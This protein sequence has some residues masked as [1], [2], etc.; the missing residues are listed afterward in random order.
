MNIPSLPEQRQINKH[1]ASFETE[2]FQLCDEFSAQSLLV[3]KLRQTILQEAIEGKLTADWRKENPVFSGGTEHDGAALL[4]KIKTK[5]RKL[6]EQGKLRKEK[7][8]APVTPEEVPFAL[9]EGWLWTRLG[10]VVN[11]ASNIVDPLKYQNFLQ[12][13]PDNIEKMTGKLKGE[14][15]TVKE[16]EV[17]SANHLFYSGMLLYSKIRPRLRK[18]VKVDFDGLCSA[19]MYPLKPMVNIDYIKYYMLSDYFDEEVYKFDN[20]VKMPKINKNQLNSIVIPLPP[21]A[22]QRAIVEYIDKLFAI[23]DNLETQVKERKAQVEGLMQA[24]LREAFESTESQKQDNS[25]KQITKFQQMQI[26]GAVIDEINRVHQ[27]QGEMIIAKYLYIL[28]YVYKIKTGFTFQKWHFGPYDISLKKIINN[29]TYFT[30]SGKYVFQT[31]GIKNQD[32]LFKY[33]N[34]QVEE[35]RN[36]FPKIL[37]IFRAYKTSSDRDRKIELLACVLKII[38]GLEI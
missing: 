32:K 2:L 38:E 15:M 25:G 20:R 27:H 1:F 35:I 37:E 11:I 14:F 28:E 30:R 23:V 24:V 7:T 36:N 29:P 6:I 3:V 16:K 21:S 13:A 5:K 8:R 17:T 22:E 4:A 26:V 34:R 9:P 19:D 18:I 31:V 12:I 33:P 10:E